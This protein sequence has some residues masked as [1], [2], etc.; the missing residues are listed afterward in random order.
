[1][2]HSSERVEDELVLCVDKTH[3]IGLQVLASRTYMRWSQKLL[4]EQAGL[5]SGTVSRIE[6][7]NY[8][9]YK[10]GPAIGLVIRC[11]VAMGYSLKIEYTGRTNKRRSQ[12]TVKQR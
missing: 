8:K 10:N 9:R 7:W 2:S 4:E 11:L 1:M 12:R 5:S 3:E 6:R